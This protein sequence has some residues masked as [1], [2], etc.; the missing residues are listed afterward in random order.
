VCSSW[1]AGGESELSLDAEVQHAH[2]GDVNS[3]A[4]QPTAETPLLAT[5]GDDGLV[6]L[7]AYK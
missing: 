5:A 2:D 7:W 1:S 4:W 3:V 6:K